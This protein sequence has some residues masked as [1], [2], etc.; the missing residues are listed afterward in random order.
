MRNMNADNWFPPNCGLTGGS[1]ASCV[2]GVAKSAAFGT[3]ADG[4]AGVKVTSCP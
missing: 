3:F 4:E 2:Y 1:S